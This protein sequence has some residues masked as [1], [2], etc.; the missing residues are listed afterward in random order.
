VF[1]SIRSTA[2]CIRLPRFTVLCI[3]LCAHFSW[4]PLLRPRFQYPHNTCPFIRLRFRFPDPRFQEPR[5]PL[6]L[7]ARP[8]YPFYLIMCSLRSHH[9]YRTGARKCLCGPISH[10]KMSM[11]LAVGGFTVKRTLRGRASISA[12]ASKNGQG[13]AIF[14]CNSRPK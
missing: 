13:S 7:R 2:L 4:L 11:L 9:F 8:T 5:A 6:F 3:R 12:Y 1:D 10:A 14:R